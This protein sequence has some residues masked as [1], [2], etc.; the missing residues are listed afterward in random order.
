MAYA[1]GAVVSGAMAVPIGYK[2]SGAGAEF[3]PAVGIADLEDGAGY[4][5]AL[6][7]EQHEFSF[8][9]LFDDGE[10][11]DGAVFYGHFDG[12][13]AAYFSMVYF[14]GAYFGF[15]FGDTDMAGA[16]VS[17]EDGVVFKIHGIVFCK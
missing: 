6:G 10:E 9:R 5:L 8:L 16:V 13:A 15:S 17:H 7:D 14:E 12:E 2:F 3:I 4:R 1:Y 11:G